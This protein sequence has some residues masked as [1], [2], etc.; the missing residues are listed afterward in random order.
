MPGW[1]YK[2][3]QAASD[4]FYEQQA[5]YVVRLY[6]RNWAAGIAGT[7]W[8][9][10]EGPG[11]RYAGMLDGYQKPKPDYNALKF[12]L[13]ELQGAI[14]R[15]EVSVNKNVQIYEFVL[16]EKR[17]WV[18]WPAGDNPQEINTPSDILQVLDIYGNALPPAGITLQITNPIYIELKP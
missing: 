9:D 2:V 10:F 17:V 7:I 16:P 8:Y 13:A 12:L 4:P 15:R 3:L 18:L 11:W 14:F 5:N 6:I 1:K